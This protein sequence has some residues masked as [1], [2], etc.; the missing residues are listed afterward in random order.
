M[1]KD[2]LRLH[3]D[4][5]FIFYVIIINYINII[6]SHWFFSPPRFFSCYGVGSTIHEKPR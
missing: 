5:G 4:S 2:C 1:K 3:Y 6:I